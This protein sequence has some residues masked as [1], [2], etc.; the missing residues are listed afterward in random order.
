VNAG[1]QLEPL[2]AGLAP[3]LL[4]A[5]RLQV[6]RVAAAVCFA[7]LLVA[8]AVGLLRAR[9]Q[10]ERDEV[11]ATLEADFLRIERE[12]TLELEGSVKP[13]PSGREER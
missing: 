3:L 2:F 5:S 4:T 12:L 7:L 9:R 8:L 10:A 6:A 11:D 1:A 13:G